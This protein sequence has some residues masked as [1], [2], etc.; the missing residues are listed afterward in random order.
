MFQGKFEIKFNLNVFQS[1][2]S[3]KSYIVSNRTVGIHRI[4][5]KNKIK[6]NASME[7]TERK[8]RVK[9]HPADLQFK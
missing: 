8:I 6:I 3:N 9:E 7:V 5:F 2:R 1:I 4:N